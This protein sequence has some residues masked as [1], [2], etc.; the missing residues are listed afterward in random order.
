MVAQPR[1][2]LLSFNA[3]KLKVVHIAENMAKMAGGVP[4]VVSQLAPRLSNIGV[5][6]QIIHATGD[7]GVSF[8]KHGILKFPPS[9]IGKPW[10]YSAEL[11][12]GLSVQGISVEGRSTVF[13]IHGVWS[14]PQYYAAKVA[15]REG[16]PFVLTSHGMLEPWL[17]EKQGSI[18]YMKK[19][20]Y[21]TAFAYPK[22]KNAAAIHAIT[23]LERESLR[24]LFPLN[25]IEVIPNAIELNE[26]TYFE[27]VERKKTILFIGRIEPKKGVDLLLYA[28]AQARLSKDWVVN[29][30][31]PVWSGAYLAI[32]KSIVMKEGLS[33][34]VIFHGPVFG[35]DKLEL[36]NSAWVLVAPS[37]SEVVGLV[38]LEAAERG[39]PT[40]TTNAT[41]L[42]DWESDGGGLLIK[43]TIESLTAALK[44]AA[45]WG[46]KERLD[47]G[48]ASRE[49]IK[50]RYSWE[51][52][53]PSW[54]ELYSSL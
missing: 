40:I 18:I 3:A 25:R 20:I 35:D 46:D 41:G 36:I 26:I 8:L 34:Q 50:K 51:A 53:M 43:P 10:S 38:N 29:I 11:K 23:P 17:W 9:K 42:Y 24:K 13:H 31:G 19:K 39:L 32:L 2:N 28:F 48:H 33:D 16:V 12:K 30:V 1:G 4:A 44:K 54:L 15:Y 7:L 14:A 52:V 37:Y 45:S 27:K 47:R 6:T 5:S 22:F 49:L 21:W